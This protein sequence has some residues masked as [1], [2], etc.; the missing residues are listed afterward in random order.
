MSEKFCAKC[1]KPTKRWLTR[2]MCGACYQTWLSRQKAYGRFESAFVPVGPVLAHLNE[3]NR[4]GLGSARIAELA[5]VPRRTV[6]ALTHSR[7]SGTCWRSRA[8]AILSVPVPTGPLDDALADGA[9]IPSA[10]TVR[11]LRAL[12][13]SGYTASDLAQRL[14]MH[15][16]VVSRIQRGGQPGVTVR[17]ARAVADLF[18]QLQMTPGPSEHA[19]TRARQLG[20]ALPL[21][22]DEDAIDN[23]SAKPF[24]QALSDQDFTLEYGK[25]RA[26]GYG[27]DQIA[28]LLG[29]HPRSLQKRLWRARRRATAAA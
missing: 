4:A 23:P 19:K 25:L 26:R 18:D 28:A 29:V 8:D 12:T 1:G 20:W 13:A 17:I 15:F 10:G 6:Q 16:Q 9:Q 24:K 3:L 14:G 22:W 11:R 21:E 5:G 2:G 7:V 27:N